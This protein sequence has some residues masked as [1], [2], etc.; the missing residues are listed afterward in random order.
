MYRRHPGSDQGRLMTLTTI[1][2]LPLIGSVLVAFMPPGLSKYMS[3]LSAVVTLGIAVGVAAAF[4]PS[5][6]QY[7]FSE[8]APWIPQLAI[9]YHL[10]VDGISIWLVVLNALLTVIAVMATPESTR[11]VSK[12]LGLIL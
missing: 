9:F 2:L 11:N 7:Q 6:H 3:T 8:Q 1:W 10:G 5:A 12:F 4:D